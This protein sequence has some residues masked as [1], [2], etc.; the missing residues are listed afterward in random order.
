MNSKYLT[1][2]NTVHHLYHLAYYQEK[3][4]IDFRK[5]NTVVEWGGGY[6]NLAKIFK[7]LVK[8]DNTYVIFDVPL[9]SCI[10]WLYLATIFGKGKVN[11]LTTSKGKIQKGKFNLIPSSVN[12]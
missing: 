11:V 8:K 5:I 3:T 2:H 6:G 12:F 10:E 9:L 4:G 1:S 7:R